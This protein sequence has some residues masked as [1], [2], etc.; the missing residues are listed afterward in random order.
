M[1]NGIVLPPCGA[2]APVSNVLVSDVAV[3]S[4]GSLFSQLTLSP[5]LIVRFGGENAKAWMVTVWIAAQAG[6]VRDALTKTTAVATKR[7]RV[8]RVRR[9]R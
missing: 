1:V 5:A 2:I 8:R 6:M 9:I 7:A 4:S 3:C